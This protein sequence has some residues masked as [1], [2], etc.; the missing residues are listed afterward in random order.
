M[1]T[2]PYN[3]TIN[4]GTLAAMRLMGWIAPSDM[5]GKVLVPREALEYAVF[6]LELL[7]K[8]TL[9]TITDPEQIATVKRLD[10][11]LQALKAALP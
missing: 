7:Q 2:K 8:L 3:V 1:K 9:S 10:V 6:E 11:H 4:D 5:A